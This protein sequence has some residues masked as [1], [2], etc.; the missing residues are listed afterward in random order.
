MTITASK[1]VP[2]AL[3]IPSSESSTRGLRP[4]LFIPVAVGVAT[5]LAA[6]GGG[7]GDAA[8]AGSPPLD[9]VPAPAPTRPLAPPTLPQASRFLAQ[10]SMG[11]DK[12]QIQQVV[13]LGFAGWLDEQMALPASGTR[14]DFLLTG[15]FDAST[16]KNNKAGF[17]A[18][19]WNKLL[20]SPDTL[21]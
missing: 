15:G 10:S 5:G 6:C 12:A 21:R 3:E 16:F 17:D 7:G 20:A 4:S 19:A 9:A 1:A 11:A 13:S 8:Q 2:T 14:W 18:A